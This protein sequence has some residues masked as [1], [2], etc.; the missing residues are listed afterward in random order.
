M[1]IVHE[2]PRAL[3]LEEVGNFES[4]GLPK[5]VT[6]EEARFKMSRGRKKEETDVGELRGK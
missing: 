6:A 2:R 3:R 4:V 1:K 5:N